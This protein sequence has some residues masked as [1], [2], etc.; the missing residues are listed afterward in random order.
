M[1]LD[2]ILGILRHVLTGVGGV[3]VAKGW[4]DDS[5]LGEAAG[6]I[7]TLVGFGW[8]VWHKRQAA[9]SGLKVLAVG[10]ALSGSCAFLSGC[11]S[12]TAT[13][14]VTG[15]DGI[16]T[17]DSI[18]VKGFLESI[19]NGTYSSTNGMVLSTSDTTPDQQSIATL[20][21][22][23]GDLGKGALALAATNSAA[24]K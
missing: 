17:S 12:A 16:V 10:F 15:A 20:A 8:S 23:V 19:G 7:C 3:L 5:S 18:T 22:I 13:R 21:G 1:K 2:I 14:T 24:T 9:L 4:A 11:I 6:A